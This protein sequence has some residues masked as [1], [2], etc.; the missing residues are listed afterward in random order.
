MQQ[1]TQMGILCIGSVNLTHLVFQ[2]KF[3]FVILEV[4]I[5]LFCLL[6]CLVNS[7]PW[8][9][10]LSNLI[11]NKFSG[12][13]AFWSPQTCLV[14]C[15]CASCAQTLRTGLTTS[16]SL[17]LSS[18]HASFTS[19]KFTKQESVSESVSQ[20]V[21]DKHSQWSDSGPIKMANIDSKYNSFIHFTIKFNSKDYSI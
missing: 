16:T 12:P 3:S 4:L 21:S 15:T 6:H 5:E 1:T 20:S 2:N 19:I 9:S 10:Q 18:P 7:T 17:E 14:P 8:F 13:P 11:S